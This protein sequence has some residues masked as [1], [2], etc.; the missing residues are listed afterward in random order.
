MWQTEGYPVEE[1]A[2]PI[3]IGNPMKKFLIA[4]V[5]VVAFSGAPALAA[6]MAVKAPPPAPVYSWTGCYIGGNTGY[7][8]AH[9]SGNS[10]G[11][12]EP[13]LG[14]IPDPY[15]PGSLTAGGWAYGGQIGCDYQFNNNGVVGIRGMWDGSNMKGSDQFPNYWATPN[16]N[17]VKSDTFGTLVGKLGYLVA[18]TVELYALGGVAWV[19]D[20]YFFTAPPAFVGEIFTGDQTRTGYDVG[21]GLSWMFARNWDLWI[22]YDHMGFGT[23][24][25]LLNGTPIY[26]TG[27][28]TPVAYSQNVDKILVGIDYRF[29]WG[30]APVVAKY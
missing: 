2:W 7:A 5:A 24:N 8:W 16:F 14:F 17:N 30:K 18:P 23:K 9:K 10:D 3:P 1:R 29:D 25:V 27:F 26:D 28:S 19:R 13:P 22:E 20:H 12:Y 6:D 15:S 11:Y 21:V 4:G